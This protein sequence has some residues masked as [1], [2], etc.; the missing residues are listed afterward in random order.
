MKQ[1][2]EEPVIILSTASPD[3]AK[4]IAKAL[5]TEKIAACVNMTGVTSYYHWKDEFCDDNEVLLIIKTLDS[6]K[7]EVMEAI[8]RLHSYELPEMIVI[9]ITGGFPPYL[10]WLKQELV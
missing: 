3:N 7:G 4:A 6:K 5:V 10:S 9:P 8:R 2:A 1:T